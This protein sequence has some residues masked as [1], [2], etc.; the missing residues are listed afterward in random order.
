MTLQTGFRI[1]VEESDKERS[2]SYSDHF[3]LLT[4]TSDLSGAL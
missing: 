2:V 3:S 4:F 1:A